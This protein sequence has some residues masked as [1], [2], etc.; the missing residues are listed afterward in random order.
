MVSIGNRL[1][2]IQ[3]G[4]VVSLE[5]GVTG[6]P[7][8]FFNRDMGGTGDLVV[9]K[10]EEVKHDFMWVRVSGCGPD[11]TSKVLWRIALPGHPEYSAEQWD[12]DGFIQPINY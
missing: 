11:G 2:W 10:I 9:G 8:W 3:V 5:L 12:R 7:R 6:Y 1:G 4:T